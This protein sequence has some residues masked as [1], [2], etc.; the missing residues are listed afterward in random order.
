[1]GRLADKDILITGGS[2]GVTVGDAGP[3]ARR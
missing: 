1:M 3:V 2:I